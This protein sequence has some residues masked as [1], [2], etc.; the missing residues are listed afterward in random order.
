MNALY[1]YVNILCTKDIFELEVAKF[2]PSFYSYE[3]LEN[4]N[5]YFKLLLV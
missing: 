2:L 1:K 5:N 4:C 3:L